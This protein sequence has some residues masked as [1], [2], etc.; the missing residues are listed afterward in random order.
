[1]NAKSNTDREAMSTGTR[2]TQ[3]QAKMHEYVPGVTVEQVAR[4]ILGSKKMVKVVPISQRVA[5]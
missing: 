5:R 2:L 3:R 4:S 1:M